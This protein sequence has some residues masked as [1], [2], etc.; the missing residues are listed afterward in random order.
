MSLQTIVNNAETI[1]FDRRRTVGIQTTRNSIVRI[2]E[3]PTRNPW[4]LNVRVSRLFRYEQARDMIE[5]LDRLDRS[6]PE[7]ITFSNNPGLSW[8]CAYRGSLSTAQLNLLSVGSFQGN[9]LI[10]NQNQALVAGTV[11]FRRGDFI[12]IADSPYPF[13]AVNDVVVPQTG[14][15]LTVTTHRPNFISDSIV[16]RSILVGNKVNFSVICMNMPVYRIQPGGSTA[17]VSFD[18]EFELH[19]FTGT[20]L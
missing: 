2:S 20:V 10:L 3:T 16:G 19:E 14:L 17:L 9:Q 18:E 6:T 1:T 8:L 7:T 15:Q 13:T 5:T 12:Q 4:R 11:A